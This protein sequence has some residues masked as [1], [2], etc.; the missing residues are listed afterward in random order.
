MI[1]NGVC[2]ESCYSAECGWDG[3]DCGCAVGCRYEELSECK[4]ECLVIDCGYGVLEG[5]S[6][7]TQEAIRMSRKSSNLFRLILDFF[8]PQY[9]HI[10][11]SRE[12][13]L[14]GFQTCNQ[15]LDF[16]CFYSFGMCSPATEVCERVTPN[17][18]LQCAA[19]L[20]N[21]L[22]V[23]LPQCVP[24]LM[25]HP[26]VT[27]FCVPGDSTSPS[28]P[29]VF[30]ID[31]DYEG[32]ERDGSRAH[33]FNSLNEGLAH[34]S[35]SNTKLLLI[36]SQLTLG[37]LGS[38][39]SPSANYVWEKEIS[40]QE[41]LLSISPLACEETT[42]CERSHI[43]AL[44][45]FHVWKE[46][47]CRDGRIVRRLRLANLIFE[48]HPSA[49]NAFYGNFMLNIERSNL[50]LTNI[51]FTGF[52]NIAILV[53]FG[54]SNSVFLRNVDF[55]DVSPSAAF[56]AS[57][58]SETYVCDTYKPS[59]FTYIN[60]RIV[61]N[62]SL[63][64]PST[65]LSRTYMNSVFISNV[66]LS[67]VRGVSEFF[68]LK[69][70]SCIS[71]ELRNMEFADN[72][73][74]SGR[75]VSVKSTKWSVSDEYI[76]VI[77]AISKTNVKIENCVFRNNSFST[78]AG[79]E[80]TYEALLQNVLMRNLSFDGEVGQLISIV[81]A[82]SALKRAK[83]VT[84]LN[85]STNAKT[86]VAPVQIILE[87]L[88]LRNCWNT[89]AELISLNQLP[90]TLVRNVTVEWP[91]EMSVCVP[92]L[93][94]VSLYSLVLVDCNFAGMKCSHTVPM[95]QVAD[96]IS[97][98]VIQ[99]C[100]FTAH[101][102]S[103]ASAI[104]VSNRGKT[105]L[106]GVR[107]QQF[108][109]LSNGAVSISGF[110]IGTLRLESVSME[111]NK[112]RIGGALY[113]S[114]L[115]EVNVSRSH[116][117]SNSAI[118]GG[119]IGV[120]ADLPAPVR[121]LI[122]ESL[123]EGN[124]ALGQGGA[125][126]I[127]F[128]FPASLLSLSLHSTTMAGNIGKVGSGLYLA[129]KISLLAPS[130]FSNLSMTDNVADTHGVLAL[131]HHSGTLVVSS[132]YCARNTGKQGTSCL[133][134]AISSLT[135]AFL[136][137]HNATFEAN[138]GID[139]VRT[140]NIALT[141][142][143]ILFRQNLN[144]SLYLENTKMNCSEC[145]FQANS[146][147][148]IVLTT[149]SAVSLK[150]AQFNSNSVFSSGAAV[151]VAD[152]TSL[153]CENCLFLNNKAEGKAGT[154]QCEG[155]SVV[156]LSDS[157]FKGNTVAGQGSALTLIA[158]RA[159]SLYNCSFTG[160]Y[161]KG[162]GTLFLT[163]ATL[164]LQ[165]CLLSNNTAFLRSAGLLINQS[166][167]TLSEC[168]LAYHSG[169]AGYFMT[170]TTL[171]EVYLERTI[172]RQ[173]ENADIGAIYVEESSL[174]LFNCQVW[175]LTGSKGA[176][177]YAFGFSNVS[178]SHTSLTNCRSPSNELVYLLLSTGLITASSFSQYSGSALRAQESSLSVRN[179][180][181]AQAY[182]KTGT[183]I[184][185]VQCE[186]LQ[187]SD[188]LFEHLEAGK[189]AAVVIEK[190]AG[191]S[192]RLRVENTKFRENLAT[193]AGA[194][195]LSNSYVE[196]TGSEFNS[197][198]A[199]ETAGGAVVFSCTD[200]LRNCS[201]SVTSS[202]F[203]N[204][205]AVLKGGAIAWE[206]LQPQ[207]TALIFLDNAAL[208]GP[209]VSSFPTHLSTDNLS[210][211]SVASGQT[212][213]G[214]LV[215]YLRDHYEQIVADDVTT[216]AG[217]QVLGGDAKIAGKTDA[218]SNSGLISFTGFNISATPGSKPRLSVTVEGL[219]QTLYLY[220]LMRECRLGESRANDECMLCEVGKY[221]VGPSVPC[222]DCPSEANCAGGDRVFPKKGYWRYNESSPKFWKCPNPESCIDKGSTVGDCEEGYEG[223]MC[224]TCALD[225]HRSGKVWC[226][227]C[228]SL[229]SSV[230]STIGFILAVVLFSTIIVF[231]S[232]KSASKPKALHS[233]Y[234]KM[235]MNYLQLVMLMGSF[236][237]SWP[238][239]T[240]QLLDM[241][242]SAGG[243]PE[244]LFSVNCLT[245]NFD[246]N[247]AFFTKV[248]LMSAV[249]LLFFLTSS[250]YWTVT[251]VIKQSISTLTN[252]LI[253][254]GMILFFLVHPSVIRVLFGVFNCEEIQ[255]G[256]YWVASLQIR[257]W[258]G[259]HLTYALAVAL[260]GLIIWGIG[261][262]T[263]ILGSLVTQKKRLN[264]ISVKLRF[265]YLYKGYRTSRFYWEFI[266]IYRKLLI[267]VIATFLSR[268]AK[269]TQTLIALSVL[270]VFLVLHH[271]SQPYS[272]ASLNTMEHRSLLVSIATVFFGLFY[273]DDS[274]TGAEYLCFALILA[275]NLYFLS[276]WFAKI[277]S[278]YFVL[279]VKRVPW[280]QQHYV[281]IN[282]TTT[283]SHRRFLR[284]VL[285]KMQ[286]S[287]RTNYPLP[288]LIKDVFI[289]KLHRQ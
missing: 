87:D 258:E 246:E 287:V 197:N 215:F 42:D 170:V 104:F 129:S 77:S 67:G 97:E 200:P 46:Y 82:V 276:Y 242:D 213:P 169:S 8:F 172:L 192:G 244:R 164:Y 159:V 118:N 178:I 111:G 39:T 123:L 119:A 50:E 89:A 270:I 45:T 263:V 257:C 14:T 105:E 153:E 250:L 16:R 289:K 25:P 58:A 189:G 279:L 253:A 92:V 13:I 134:I 12:D 158:A 286:S 202:M 277:L 94:T 109:G 147:A 116:F 133:F 145:S 91:G 36:G 128:D 108:T 76:D 216:K 184:R 136:S 268:I 163:S 142:S 7:C 182:S 224:Q 57:H 214:S 98:V 275:F 176:V 121:V 53:S 74:G 24:G 132:L 201:Y 78:G 175:G 28:N 196:I 225:Y 34:C 110:T 47:I 237:L 191:N 188:C 171:S 162:G 165:N 221:W 218:T 236:N 285:P 265:G 38:T 146:G 72:E 61:F 117:R 84:F 113:L 198:R 5:Y 102:A 183:G 62:S 186:T 266:V 52:Q 19:G 17:G 60:G 130:L 85:T 211:T 15:N 54:N 181:F 139:I 49:F 148:G 151:Q 88:T 259:R 21:S 210:L 81:S 282:E 241:Q 18:C 93:W 271:Y 247:K 177:I 99:D 254:S 127:S 262:P 43:L 100:N 234:L 252:Q 107:V 280:L 20:V 140:N 31:S 149:G 157:Q 141:L 56:F 185:C 278:T 243:F 26:I 222:A 269:M 233:V 239:L 152:L 3:V 260:P 138:S 30:Y 194:M 44:G 187:V 37:Q 96:S 10:N 199:N 103:N 79:L 2:E 204:N 231:A 68:F 22:G 288:A 65:F 125:I 1:G 122:A 4:E 249:P 131:N 212:F 70:D 272:H 137:V 71:L 195:F 101:P 59:N 166:N 51:T 245:D 32:S 150:N 160:N 48:E 114:N 95:L 180:S 69:V 190:K 203:L 223:N 229:A 261:V 174:R 232:I 274:L 86:K 23:C 220:V 41:I 115:A 144:T 227:R 155:N 168:E 33:P 284:T 240:K 156:R 106:I 83:G 80:F 73:M 251:A 66:T 235:L 264:D 40:K 11:C 90:Y 193:E 217:L 248:A 63:A 167:V 154:L 228:P 9:N 120:Y 205:S 112:A 219:S 27:D 35:Y 126:Y 238:T 255:P 124:Q 267:I 179:T 209:D 29:M 143:N 173:G 256:E 273:L 281:V 283:T 64:H 208:Y 75:F 55:L 206:G 6:P 207:L 135:T 230:A 226:Q 161:A